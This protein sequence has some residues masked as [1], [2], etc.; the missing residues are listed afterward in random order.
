[1]SDIED[2]FKSAT[3]CASD[4]LGDSRYGFL[5]PIFQRSYA[6]S[7]DKVGDMVE[8]IVSGLSAVYEKGQRDN[9]TYIGTFITTDGVGDAKRARSM[10]LPDN[11]ISL[12]DGQQR[13][14]TV[15]LISLVLLGELDEFLRKINRRIE[16][17]P[18]PALADLSDWV[19]QQITALERILTYQFYANRGRAPKLIRAQTD[20][21]VA[22][23]AHYF[24]PIAYLVTEYFRSRELA[25]AFRPR[26]P[27]NWPHGQSNFEKDRFLDVRGAIQG[28]MINR[29][30]QEL[31]DDWFSDLPSYETIFAQQDINELLFGR[32]IPDLSVVE[33]EDAD[34]FK[35]IVRLQAF[36]GY[37][38]KRVAMTVVRG[39]T[40]DIAFEVFERLNTTGEPLNPYETFKPQVI[41][42]IPLDQYANSRESIYFDH[43]DRVFS[44]PSTPLQRAKLVSDT[45][46]LFSLAQGGEK[47]GKSLSDQVKQLKKSFFDTQ[48]DAD[49]DRREEYLQ[50]LWNSAEI[51]HVFSDKKFNNA[52]SFIE[53]IQNDDAVKLCCAFLA[54]IRHTVAFPI[55]ARFYSDWYESN[56]LQREERC[57]PQEVRT[58]IKAVTAFSILWRTAWGGTAG[59]DSIYR[60][61]MSGNG[62]RPGFSKMASSDRRISAAE[63]KAELY[64]HLLQEKA[65]RDG[66]IEDKQNWRSYAR[67]VPIGKQIHLAKFILLLAQHDCVPDAQN[68]GL[69]TPGVLN[70]HRYFR[71]ENFRNDGYWIEHIAPRAAVEGQWDADV[72]DDPTVK[73]RLGNLVILPDVDN[74]ISGNQ[75]WDIKKHIYKALTQ[76]NQTDREA[77]IRESSLQL[78]PHQRQLILESEYQPALE[79]IIKRDRWNLDIVM[80]RTDRLL[81]IVWDRLIP[82][83]R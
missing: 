60:N 37:F 70:S 64:R 48:T 49:V 14:S 10:D 28:V 66:P 58:V 55:I 32:R 73:D 34:S 47:I 24:S 18:T 8:D 35:N 4:Y 62:G 82:W 65:G 33:T 53:I 12:V 51:S 52:S 7:K 6:W 27:T 67:V 75:A 3:F 17:S 69:I 13:I 5:I 83:L 78:T 26:N 71:Y 46:I 80:K 22:G 43:I 30:Y 40:E 63:L 11:V 77:S 41:R 74:I 68:P 81:N 25:Q 31:N 9:Y 45:L 20:R 72:Y 76:T 44:R 38:L 2:K 23:G 57:T 79:S 56:F 59:I 1:M 29:Q 16:N 36:S 19:S 21:W 54:E 39:M 61:I 50:L 15:S 42:L